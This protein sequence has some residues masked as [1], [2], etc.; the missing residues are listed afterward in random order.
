M[1]GAV[2]GATPTH[3]QKSDPWARQGQRPPMLGKRKTASIV[4]RSAAACYAPPW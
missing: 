3:Q 4:T 2:A 1:G